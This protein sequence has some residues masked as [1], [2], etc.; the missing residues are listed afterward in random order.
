MYPIIPRLFP[1]SVILIKEQLKEPVAFLWIL[2][3]PSLIFYFIYMTTQ[4]ENRLVISYLDYSAYYYAYVA[5]TVSFFGFSFYLVGRRESGFIR[6]FAYSSKAKTILLLAQLLSYSA[7]SLAYCTFL[8]LLTRPL[9]GDYEVLEFAAILLRFYVC[10]LMF[11]V[12]GVLLAQ[13]K[14]TFQNAHTL[15]SALLFM[16]LMLMMSA[17]MTQYEIVAIVNSFNPLTLAS[18]IMLMEGWT[19]IGASGLIAALLIVI[20]AGAVK[21]MPIN[22]VWSR[23]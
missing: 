10:F 11:C 4:L 7:I 6:S 22:P 3:S 8:Y 5:S 14:L 9:F 19:L 2:L 12:G 15:Y 23:Y 21:L 20:M 16:M 13:L 1:L 17:R 18:N